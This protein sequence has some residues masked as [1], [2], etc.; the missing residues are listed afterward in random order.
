MRLLSGIAVGICVAGLLFFSLRPAP[1]NAGRTA[2]LPK[3]VARWLNTHDH[4]A[5]FLAFAGLGTLAAFATR[6]NIQKRGSGISRHAS[7]LVALA[8]LAA[9]LEI[10]QLFIPGRV[11]D[12]KDILA[13]WSALVLVWI[14]TLL[15]PRKARL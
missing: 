10:T 5:N 13:A 15:P 8:L 14:G 3:P 12:L 6:R 2:G 9:A 7:V 4:L 1:V 11:C